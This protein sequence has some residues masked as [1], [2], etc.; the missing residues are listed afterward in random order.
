MKDLE[1][2]EVFSAAFA[3]VFTGKVYSQA[4]QVSTPCG[5]VR[6]RAVLTKNGED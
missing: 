1:W 2:A 6:G 5:S 4:S 3:A